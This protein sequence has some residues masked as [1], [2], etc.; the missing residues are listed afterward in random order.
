MTFCKVFKRNEY[1]YLTYVKIYDIL[2]IQ[3]GDSSYKKRREEV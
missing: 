3:D 2:Y 1:I